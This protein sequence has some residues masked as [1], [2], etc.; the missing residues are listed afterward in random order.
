MTDKQAE[1]AVGIVLAFILFG[2]IAALGFWAFA[3]L[4][5]GNF[6]AI[7]PLAAGVGAFAAIAF[8]IGNS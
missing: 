6:G 7:L 8:A 2:G 5:G 4:T 1:Y 3:W